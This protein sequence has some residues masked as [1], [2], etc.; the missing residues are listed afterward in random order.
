MIGEAGRVFATGIVVVYDVACPACSAVARELPELVRV[1][2]SV[3]ACR[4]PQLGARYP[5]LPASVRG[6]A[7][8]AIGTGGRDGT[9]RWWLGLTGAVGLAPVLRPR[10]AAAA[11][12]L[13]WTA[14]AG[15]RRRSG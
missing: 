9:V 6:C 4:D 11:G 1:P 5:R 12:L 2:V 13:L 3:V 14:F 8:P 7:T 15:S 10:G